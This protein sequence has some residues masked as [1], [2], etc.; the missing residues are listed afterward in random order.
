MCAEV[1]YGG[2]PSRLRDVP[3]LQF[4]THNEPFLREVGAWVRFVA[5]ELHARRLLAP[6]GGPVILVQLENEYSMVSDA[7]GDA[8]AR[9]LQ[10]CADLQRELDFAV[11]AIMCYGAAD[12]V[13]ETINAFYAHK[14]LDDH[15]S[16]HPDQP[17]VWTECWTGWYD[18]WGAPHHRRP[19]EDLAYAV[20]RFFAQGGAGVNYYMW[21]G[22]TNFGRSGMYLQASS[23]DYDAPIDEFY[24]E[25]TKS[26]HLARLHD[27]LLGAFADAF[28]G[29][30]EE[31]PAC[32]GGRLFRWGDVCF[33]CNDSDDAFCGVAL[34]GEGGVVYDG[35]VKGKSVHIVDARD[36]KLLFD[37]S[38]VHEDDVVVRKR[39]PVATEV[40]S[41][42]EW[43]S[44]PVP[45]PATAIHITES[46]SGARRVVRSDKAV[47]QL[48]LTR[49]SSDYSFFTAQFKREAGGSAGKVMLRFEAADCATVFIDGEYAGRTAEPLW[50]DR[51]A[52]KW[53]A[54]EDSG[55]G[56]GIAHEV[57]VELHGDSVDVTVLTCAMGLVKGD[58]QLGTRGM[59][60]ERKGL[61]SDVAVA[62]WRRAGS[63]LSVGKLAG[64]VGEF[65][66]GKGAWRRGSVGGGPRWWRCAVRVPAAGN[67]VVDLGAAGKG[68]LYAGGEPLARFWDVRGT[69][70]RNGFLAQSPVV[71]DA[72]GAPTQRWYHVPPWL[73]EDGVL[74]VVL[75]CERGGAPPPLDV[76][77]VE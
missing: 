53:N 19:P 22:G 69:R 14:E 26:R 15:R 50:E 49:D 24:Q 56:P 57:E 62:G 73:L 63:W 76:A 10:W 71:Q 39:V 33:V 29:Q 7:Y 65:A 25:T 6:A 2:F 8:G 4:R 18:V 51:W 37:T 28:H 72:A 17:P 32:E 47:E 27:V 48:L 31:D 36:G 12:G 44:E 74:H 38:R 23:Y 1:S 40:V 16:R 21:M 68:M 45:V 64:E 9:Y 20:A 42:W 13:V 55:G 70:P 3:G 30:R 67:L 66:A 61:L 46:S 5:A 75:F 58:W 34:D 77:A 59:R 43:A 54:Y 11:P 60:A 41:D 35:E 52:N